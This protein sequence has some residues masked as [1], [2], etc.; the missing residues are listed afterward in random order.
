MKKNLLLTVSTILF[1]FSA[2][3]GDKQVENK[4]EIKKAESSVV[5]S[6][7]NN[8][9]FDESGEKYKVILKTKQN[10]KIK[11]IKNFFIIRISIV[12]KVLF[13]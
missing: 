3:K 12:D 13:V 2:C 7:E 9:S 5:K 1:L 8:I 6:V 11:S 10:I 4:N